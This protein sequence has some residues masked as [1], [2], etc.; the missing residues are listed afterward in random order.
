[1]ADGEQQR[2]SAAAAEPGRTPG[3]GWVPIPDPTTLTTEAVERATGVFRREIAALRETIETRM[4]GNDEQRALIWAEIH[5]WPTQIDRVLADRRR[6]F[7]G[8][9]DS[10]RLLIEQR[11]DGMDKAV[12]L[13]TTELT[14]FVGLLRIE[15]D[16]RAE[17]EREY[18][19]SQIENVRAV[20]NEK[21]I[22]VDGRFGESKVAV[23]A[24]FAA[25]KEA[26]AEQNK[27][28][29][30]EIG[31]SEAATKEQLA[32]LSRVTDAGIAGLSDKITDARDR[33]TAIENLTQ[34][35]R[36]ATMEGRDTR[37]E[38]R[39]NT[40]AAIAVISTLLL[41]IS[42]AVTIIIATRGH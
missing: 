2:Y 14:K 11:L 20:T 5:T 18:M 10:T 32:S 17:S 23:D 36:E 13:A 39:L 34:G 9:L 19:M 16:N 24:A 8:D 28:N 15:R 27:S 22:A 3:G 40:N 35:I 38:Q 7:Q 26:V 4:A 42:I 25:A 29:A 12:A 30:R 41:V 37:G 31:K 1:M 33:I 21:F 6:E